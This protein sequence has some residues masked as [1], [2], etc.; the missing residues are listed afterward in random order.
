MLGWPEIR[1]QLRDFVNIPEP[2]KSDYITDVIPDGPEGEYTS[3]KV[4]GSPLARLMTIM[5]WEGTA[6]IREKY[7]VMNNKFSP[8]LILLKSGTLTRDEFINIVKKCNKII[9]DM[10]RVNLRVIQK[11]L[12]D[13]PE[14]R[15]SFANEHKIKV[16]EIPTF[17]LPGYNVP[18]LKKRL[19]DA[20]DEGF[21]IIHDKW[22]K[23]TRPQTTILTHNNSQDGDSRHI[24]PNIVNIS[25]VLA[26]N[27]TCD[28]IEGSYQ[29]N[30]EQ[31]NQA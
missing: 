9:D 25:T 12:S 3:L 18:E 31:S 10:E 24:S 26:L 21:K 2:V 4:L 27:L 1:P 7:T 23:L 17:K 14:I 13:T 5:G 28:A 22:K 8:L 16:E 11:V 20:I 19:T 29:I 30:L 6:L 15:Q